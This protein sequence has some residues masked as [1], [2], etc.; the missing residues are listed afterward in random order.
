MVNFFRGLL[1]GMGSVFRFPA[2]FIYRYPYYFPA[3]AFRG[4]WGKIN[5]DIQ[6]AFGKGD[7]DE[8]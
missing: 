7:T 5:K 4:D 2:A 3:E 1:L 8:R 6:I